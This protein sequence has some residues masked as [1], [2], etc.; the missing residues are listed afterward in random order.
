[1]PESPTELVRVVSV[2]D[3]T[4]DLAAMGGFDGVR[5][6]ASSRDA[7]LLVFRNGDASAAT[8]VTLA[9][10]SNRAFHR[11]VEVQPNE[12]M[13]Y[14]FA[15]LAAVRGI[16][17]WRTRGGPFH[18]E[19]WKPHTKTRT[20]TLDLEVWPEEALEVVSAALVEDLGK[21]C[22]DRTRLGQETVDFF[23]LPPGCAVLMW[24]RISR[25][26]TQ[27]RAT[28]IQ[29]MTQSEGGRSEQPT[30]ATASENSGTSPS[31]ELTANP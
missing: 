31:P 16:E 2:T 6:Y 24:P 13:R 17:G 23:D 21:W 15:F 5:D 14:V 8:W 1:M 29:A 18:A 7:S 9:P 10:I 4:L 27:A 22:Y 12:N 26:V 28:A 11:F 30:D 25:A 3:P 20:K 19:P